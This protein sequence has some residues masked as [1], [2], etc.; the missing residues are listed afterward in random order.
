MNLTPE[1]LAVR[2]AQGLP[3][4]LLCFGDEPERLGASIDLIGQVAKTR[5]FIEKQVMIVESSADWAEFVF[6]YQEQSLFSSQRLLLVYLNIKFSPTQS[7]QWQTL[8]AHPNP[9]I[10]LVVRAG[11]LDKK[12]QQA[13]W[14]TAVTTAK[15][16][17]VNSKALEGRALLDWLS[18]KARALGMTI[19]PSALSQLAQWSQG[20]LL[21]AHQSLQRWQLQGVTQVDDALLS[22]DQQD[23]A[24]FDVF[25]L[26][27]SVTRLDLT[28]SLR[29]FARLQDEGEDV[30]LILWAI[31]REVRLWKQLLLLSQQKSWS[32]AVSELGIWRDRADGL[33]KICRQLS[34]AVIDRWLAQLF[35]IDQMI[36]GQVSGSPATAL[37]WLIADLVSLGRQLPA[38]ERRR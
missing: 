28:Q 37:Q 29:I 19:T 25:A 16:W 24:R 38:L 31:S 5:G 17:L 33:A 9:D 2:L 35:A 8:L 13:K 14:V 36:K 1:L 15:G 12:A 34:L 20:N 10:L 6:S 7:E 3:P 23:W 26:M 32:Q 11:A 30:V 22:L 18:Q 27:D 21:A 4:V